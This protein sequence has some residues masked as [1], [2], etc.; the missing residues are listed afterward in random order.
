M[1]SY[2]CSFPRTW[3]YSAPGTTPRRAAR[4]RMLSAPTPSALMMARASAMTRSRVSARRRPSSPSGGVN[5]SGRVPASSPTARRLFSTSASGCRVWPHLTVN[6]VHYMVNI[7]ARKRIVFTRAVFFRDGRPSARPDARENHMTVMTSWDLFED[8]RAT[9]DELVRMANRARGRRPGQ[10]YDADA[11]DAF[12]APAVDIS[13]T[14]DAYRVTA[15][16]PGVAAGEKVHRSERCYGAFRRSITLPSHV[17]ADK[18]EASAQDGVLQILVPK[19]EEV[20]AKRIQVRAG[21][22][23]TAVTAGAS[24][25]NGG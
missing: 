19:A 24:A 15:E 17:Q 23:R 25:S 13:E 9:Q 12:W 7:V 4:V 16:I 21:Q 3:R 5:H 1:R 14:K 2:N 6:V 11:S 20:Q 8:L 22:G 18:I 10:Q